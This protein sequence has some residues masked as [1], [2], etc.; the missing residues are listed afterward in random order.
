MSIPTD[1]PNRD[2]RQG[3]G[4]DAQLSGQ[5]SIF[6]F[7]MTATWLKFL[8]YLASDRSRPLLGNGLILDRRLSDLAA[9]CRDMV[10]ELDANGTLPD[11]TPFNFAFRPAGRVYKL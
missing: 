1:C 6:N 9:C 7:D 10:S 3:Y 8:R 5:E 2:E 11:T 4:G